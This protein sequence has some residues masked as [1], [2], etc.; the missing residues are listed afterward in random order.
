MINLS[1]VLGRLTAARKNL[2]LSQ[3]EAGVL[4]GYSPRAATISDIEKNRMGISLE[5]FITLCNIYEVEPLWVLTGIH[6]NIDIESTAQALTALTLDTEIQLK[7]LQR[8]Y[9]QLAHLE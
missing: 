4:L 8:L 1:Q 7:S 6:P 2:K 9:D 5:R 3:I